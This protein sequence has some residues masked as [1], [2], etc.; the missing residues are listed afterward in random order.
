MSQTP[1]EQHNDHDRLLLLIAQPLS[2]AL[3][4]VGGQYERAVQHRTSHL[5]VLVQHAI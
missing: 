2:H 3:R 5:A 4:R 1:A